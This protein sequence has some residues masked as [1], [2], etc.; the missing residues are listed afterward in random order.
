VEWWGAKQVLLDM[1]DRPEMVIEA[2]SRLVDAH[3]SLLD[4]AEALNLLTLN[5]DNT[6][7]GS[8]GYGYT[9]ELP[10]EPYSP[11]HPVTKNMWGSSAAQI[12]TDVSPGMHWEFALK[13]EMRWLSRW[14]LTYYGCCDRLENKMDLLR[15]VANLRKIS[16]SPWANVQKLIACAGND[17]VLS[18]KPSPAFLAFEDWNPEAVRQDLL[19]FLQAAKGLN[20]E[21]ILKDI[22]TVRYKPERLREW[23]KIAMDVAQEA[24]L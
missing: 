15:K 1:V 23:N 8:G 19:E 12:F 17:Y 20:V 2:I 18:R 10:G 7:I 16:V 6:R 3:L 14:G 4:Q 9:S 11:S 24:A 13:H 5:N 22:S 21:L